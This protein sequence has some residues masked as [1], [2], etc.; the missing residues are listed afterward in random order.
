MG[1]LDGQQAIL[2][3]SWP[4]RAIRLAQYFLYDMFLRKTDLDKN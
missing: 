4:F 2:S 1:I 3:V